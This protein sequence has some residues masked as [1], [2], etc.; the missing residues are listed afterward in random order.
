MPR[1]PRMRDSQAP[2][3]IDPALEAEGNQVP[4]VLGGFGTE[5]CFEEVKGS[6]FRG[7]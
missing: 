5:N 4:V 6:G 1:A 2:R 7:R 3:S